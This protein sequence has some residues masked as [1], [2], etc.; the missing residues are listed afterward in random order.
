MVRY[1]IFFPLLAFLVLHGQ[2]NGLSIRGRLSETVN[3]RYG[4]RTFLKQES[5]LRFNAQSEV[6]GAKLFSTVDVRY[7]PLFSEGEDFTLREAYAKIVLGPFD[8]RVGRQIVVWG[9][10]DEFNP[11]DFINPEDYREFI[12]LSRADRKIGIF[13]PRIDYYWE[14]FKFECIVIPTFTPSEIPLD[15][16]HPWSPLVVRQLYHD[17]GVRV[18]E[19]DR[20]QP[21]LENAEYATRLSAVTPGFDFSFSLYSGYFDIPVMVRT[22]FIL[23]DTV[24]IT[25]TYKKCQAAGLDF[26][27]VISGWGVRGECAY[28]LRGYYETNA[29]TDTDGIETSPAFSFILGIDRSFGSET[30]LNLQWIEQIVPGHKEGMAVDQIENRFLASGYRSFL[31]DEITVGFSA[32][33]YRVVDG[34]YLLHPYVS[35]SPA[36]GVSI[37]IGLYV[38]G[39]PETSLFGQFDANDCISLSASFFF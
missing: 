16:A 4:D 10:A 7:D 31:Y 27:S 11:T 1:R 22:G 20:P 19:A 30:Y 39:G 3:M 34:D 9:K 25:P 21:V 23:P 6:Q 35:Y 17:P 14:N 37:E 13:F 18:M 32:M 12:A 33:V 26:A 8:V 2:G 29:T 15:S 38:L 28:I 36:D 24:L 5:W